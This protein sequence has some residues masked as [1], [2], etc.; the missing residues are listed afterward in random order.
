[1]KKTSLLLLLLLALA[2]AGDW[3]WMSMA[4]AQS[5]GTQRGYTAQ[6]ERLITTLQLD[7]RQ[8]AK[9]DAITSEMLPRF[10]ALSSMSPQARK[11]ARAKLTAE[12]QQKINAMLTPDQR[13][14]YE[15][16]QAKKEAASPAAVTKDAA[17]AA[18]GS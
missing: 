2:G 7:A 10:L 9:L 6:R 14:A 15:L 16:M 17:S 18:A 4:T 1:M 5:A 3:A 12:A 11:P 8:Q 13:A